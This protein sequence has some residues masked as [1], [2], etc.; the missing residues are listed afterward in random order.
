MK[1]A[2]FLAT[3]I[4]VTPLNNHV[5]DNNNLHFVVAFPVHIVVVD[6]KLNYAKSSF[7]YCSIHETTY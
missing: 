5:K 6:I 2:A 4:A 1:K 3:Q 7:A